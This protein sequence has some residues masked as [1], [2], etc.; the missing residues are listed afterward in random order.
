[1]NCYVAFIVI[2]RTFLFKK[3]KKKKKRTVKKQRSLAGKLG[4]HVPRD[5][6]SKVREKQALICSHTPQTAEEKCFAG[7][8]PEG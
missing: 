4:R 3:K 5:P 7:G 8:V 1:M 2:L 6:L